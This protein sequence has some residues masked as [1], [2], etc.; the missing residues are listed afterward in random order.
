MNHSFKYG[1]SDKRGFMLM[2][3][4]PEKVTTVFA[5]LDDVRRT[6]LLEQAPVAVAGD[7]RDEAIRLLRVHGYIT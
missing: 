5:G 2:E 6:E 3:I 4:R 7:D 1:R